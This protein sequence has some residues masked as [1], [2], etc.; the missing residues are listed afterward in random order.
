MDLSSIGEYIGV[1]TT[2]TKTKIKEL[3]M[4]VK[5]LKLL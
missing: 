5:S 2:P 4:L 1:F 3:L